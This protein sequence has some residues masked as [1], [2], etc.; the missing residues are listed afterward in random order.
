MPTKH[1]GF[2]SNCGEATAKLAV[3]N[4]SA[5][6]ALATVVFRASA[7]N[8]HFTT[9]A[10]ARDPYPLFSKYATMEYGCFGSLL[11]APNTDESFHGRLPAPCA[12]PVLP[13]IG[14]DLLGYER[15]SFSP[16]VE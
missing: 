12:V 6:T 13:A 15:K 9:G 16:V 11:K 4:G 10:A 5:G 1:S 3:S 2:G 8:T 14:N 7:V